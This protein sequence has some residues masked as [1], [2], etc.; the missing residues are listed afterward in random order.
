MNTK[1]GH[2]P[3]L[4]RGAQNFKTRVFFSMKSLLARGGSWIGSDL[5]QGQG[6]KRE[7]MEP[8]D[9]GCYGEGWGSRQVLRAWAGFDRPQARAGRAGHGGSGGGAR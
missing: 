7:R 5:Q 4:R 3:A 6:A 2:R 8:P 9:V 1:A